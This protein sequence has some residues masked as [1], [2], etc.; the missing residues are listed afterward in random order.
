MNATVTAAQQ[1]VDRLAAED[2]RSQV[3]CAAALNHQ[4]AALAALDLLAR[5]AKPLVQR[6]SSP[7]NT[8]YCA[9]A[10]TN[11]TSMHA[12]V[13]ISITKVHELAIHKRILTS[14]LDPLEDLQHQVHNAH[15]FFYQTHLA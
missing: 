1:E 6:V 3:T 8:P 13:H 4:D 11:P 12:N 9:P 10:L 14:R 5:G 15:F 7:E 2:Q